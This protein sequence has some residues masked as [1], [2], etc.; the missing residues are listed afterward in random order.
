MALVAVIVGLYLVRSAIVRSGVE[1]QSLTFVLDTVGTV[2]L[3]WN[4]AELDRRA[5][6]ALVRQVR[7]TG[8]PHA[9]DFTHFARL[10]ARV[11]EL[12]CGIGDYT[13]LKDETRNYISVNYICTA[14]FERG[15][16]SIVLNIMRD[17]ED[18]PWRVG[19]FDV[20]SPYLAA[21]SQQ[22]KK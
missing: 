21:S 9:L 20:V 18:S 12:A 8:N 5:D 6:S 1:E 17:K 15:P 2:S 22:E 4:R 14:Q 3:N 16:A 13:T 11:S 7:A 10:G 19:Y